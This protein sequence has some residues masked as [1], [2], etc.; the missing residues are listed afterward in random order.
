MQVMKFIEDEE[1]F[2]ES[3]RGL[4]LSNKEAE[5]SGSAFFYE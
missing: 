4:F 2:A 3:K 1:K 5:F